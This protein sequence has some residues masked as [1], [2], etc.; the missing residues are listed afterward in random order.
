MSTVDVIVP[1][2]RYGHFLTDCVQSVLSQSGVDVRV[3]IIDD[4]SPDHTSQIA[5]DLARDPR[6]SFRIHAQNAGHIATYN[7]GL[8]WARSDYLLLLSADDYLLPNA[9]CQSVRLLDANPD[10]GFTFGQAL[11]SRDEMGGVGSVKTAMLDMG[12][13]ALRDSGMAGLGI[14]TGREFLKLCCTHGAANVV[15]TPTAVIRTEL[16]HRVGGYRPELPH[17]ADMELW[18]RLAG[19]GAVGVVREAQAI[20]RK[21]AANMSHAYYSDARLSDLMQRRAAIDMFIANFGDKPEFEGIGRDLYSAL[22]LTAMGQ[23]SGAFNANRM[24]LCQQIANLAR[25]IDPHVTSTK[26]W[27]AL[28]WKRR[29]GHRLASALVATRKRLREATVGTA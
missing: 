5:A 27:M 24:S 18:M 16:Q 4:A 26:P 29:L 11:E 8:M 2:Y 20:Y 22:A 17:A 14:L 9:L 1:C 7:E 12:E 6:V 28:A 21:H 10:V 15:P 23:A 19:H 13:M 3:L 25:E